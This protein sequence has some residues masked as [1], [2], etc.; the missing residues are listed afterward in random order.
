MIT[1]TLGQVRE[2]RVTYSS[3]GGWGISGQADTYSADFVSVWGTASASALRILDAAW[4]GRQVVITRQD[5]R[6]PDDPKRR[7]V[8]TEATALAAE[9]VE[10]WHDRLNEWMF[11]ESVARR[12]EME[13]R[14]NTQYNRFVPPHLPGRVDGGTARAER[15]VPFPG[16][17][18]TPEDRRGADRPRRRLPPRPLRRR[19]QDRHNGRRGDADAPAGYPPESRFWWYRTRWSHSSAWSSCARSPTRRC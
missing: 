17:V 13:R 18:R 19:R 3:A 15:R 11:D 6:Y 2:L 7:I 16:P 14:W 12:E 8:D 9:K 10:K 1:D 5:P 4:S